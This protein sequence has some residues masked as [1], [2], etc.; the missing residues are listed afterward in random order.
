MKGLF[1]ILLLSVLEYLGAMCSSKLFIHTVITQ[2]TTLRIFTTVKTSGLMLL[3]CCGLWK[4]LHKN[5][6]HFLKWKNIFHNSEEEKHK[7]NEP[8]QISPC[9]RRMS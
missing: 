9:L 3:Y 4:E 6:G 8:K 1:V 7:N 2:K 5:Q